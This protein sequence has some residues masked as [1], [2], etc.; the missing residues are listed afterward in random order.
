MLY[1]ISIERDKSPREGDVNMKNL[2]INVMNENGQLE[3]VETHKVDM[4]T[5]EKYHW[6]LE[7]LAFIEFDFCEFDHYYNEAWTW[8]IVGL[9]AE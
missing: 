6:N 1:N 2:V 9:F 7:R 3:V 5:V 8:E 4:A